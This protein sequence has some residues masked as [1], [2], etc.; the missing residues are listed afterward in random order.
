[1]PKSTVFYLRGDVQ[2]QF[3]APSTSTETRLL[4]LPS[5]KGMFYMDAWDVRS[6]EWCMNDYNNELRLRQ[7]A[8]NIAT[9]PPVPRRV[10]IDDGYECMR[11][12]NAFR[13]A[14]GTRAD[15]EMNK[16]LDALEASTDRKLAQC[17]QI[18]MTKLATAKTWSREYTA[19]AEV[20]QWVWKNRKA[21]HELFVARGRA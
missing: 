19:I 3:F 13:M 1:M 2:T 11:M 5:A 7:D 10:G 18:T 20:W 9:A 16:A 14:Y 12:V 15:A 8:Y 6:Y 21:D 17:P 4:V